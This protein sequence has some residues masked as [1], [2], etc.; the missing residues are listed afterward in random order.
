MKTATETL[1]QYLESIHTTKSADSY[2]YSIVKFLCTN[3]DAEKY[4]YQN[5]VDYLLQLKNE[6]AAGTY[7]SKILASIK[8]YY[9]YLIAIGVRNDHPCR[10]LHIKDNR[11]KG[12]NFEELFSTE[13]LELLLTREERY[14]YLGHRNKL[15]ISL[16]IYQGLTSDE[17]TR[18]TVQDLD[19]EEATI[20][21]KASRKLSGR[22]LAMHRKQVVL[23]SRY[24][25]DARPFLI[26]KEIPTNKLMITKLGKPESVDGIH[27][28]LEPLKLLFPNKKLHSKAIRMSVIANW[29][30]ERKIPLEDAQLMAGHKWPSSTERYCRED[31]EEQ[32]RVINEFHPLNN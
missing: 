5:I 31:L 8:K 14:R 16:L 27:A 24:L 2:H 4:T 12:L 1:M 23:V 28:M 13:E 25:E 20:K 10:R 32:R 19:V 21:V 6:G 30:N 29:L 22:T 18:L 11:K 15:L 17:I 9:D 26:R 7:R 3:P